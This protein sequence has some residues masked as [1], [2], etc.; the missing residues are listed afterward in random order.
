M[1]SSTRKFSHG[2]PPDSLQQQQVVVVAALT[3]KTGSMMAM[4]RN[5]APRRDNRR[6]YF[7]IKVKTD[8]FR[9]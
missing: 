3:L 5:A 1:K 4:Y 8:Y 9:F 6:I 2:L 7:W